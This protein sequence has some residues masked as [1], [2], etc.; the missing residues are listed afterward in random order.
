[1]GNGGYNEKV[2]SYMSSILIS[3]LKIK[4]FES[5]FK[6]R[7]KGNLSRIFSSIIER[8]EK[9][10]SILP[11]VENFKKLKNKENKKI[12]DLPI[13]EILEFIL[14]TLHEELNENKK[15]EN[16]NMIF[17]SYDEYIKNYN[18]YNKSIIQ[19]LFFGFYKYKVTC[20]KCKKEIKQFD[21]FTIK[22]FDLTE[23]ENSII[24]LIKNNNEKIIKTLQCQQCNKSYEYKIID[25]ANIEFPD[26]L[27][28]NFNKIEKCNIKDYKSNLKIGKENYNLIC[29]IAKVPYLYY[30]NEKNQK[31][32]VKYDVFYLKNNNWYVYIIDKEKY[33]FFD[34]IKRINVNPLIAFYQKDKNKLKDCYYNLS[35]ILNDKKDILEQINEHIIECDKFDNYYIINNNWYNKILKIFESEEN[36]KNNTYL[37]NENNFIKINELNNIDYID[38]YKVFKER[39]NIIEDGS[40]KAED[41]IAEKDSNIKY[42]KNFM[43]IKEDSFNNFLDDLEIKKDN[44]KKCLYQIKFWENH[45]FIK[46]KNDKGEIRIFVCSFID[47]IFKVFVFLN[48]NSEEIFKEEI[49]N[50]ICNKGG[51]EY[52]YLK[53]NIEIKNFEKQ[54]I[55]NEENNEIGFL[56]KVEKLI[57]NKNHEYYTKY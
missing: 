8:M 29:F 37:I 18:E 6:I 53:R 38:K 47:N 5:F 21:K 57:K 30:L 56:I 42:P 4:E 50:Y 24:D 55:I 15:E 25:H 17:N 48:Y 54:K 43:L 16:N 1:M 19:K 2:N 45:V 27:I 33:E 35:S 12:E 28:I 46:E 49:K 22:Y 13:N 11:K 9:N 31:K 39:I 23:K 14:E 36:Y 52:Y 44:Y 40:F 3:F 20:K 10:N 41:E 32:D 7:R 26:I 51:L 34:G